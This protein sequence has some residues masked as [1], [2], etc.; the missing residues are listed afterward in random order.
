MTL[1]SSTE[2]MAN[3]SKYIGMAFDGE[4]VVVNYRA[5][6]VKLT[7]QYGGNTITPELQAK[8]DQARKEYREGKCITVTNHDEMRQFL[9][10]L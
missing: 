10:S 8:I 6:R 1:I 2:F 3:R 9:D 5:G 4:D 7:P